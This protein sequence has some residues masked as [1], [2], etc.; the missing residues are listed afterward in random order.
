MVEFMDISKEVNHIS[1]IIAREFNVS[2][3]EEKQM[4][5]KG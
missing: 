4:D 5:C 3:E 2:I 1:G